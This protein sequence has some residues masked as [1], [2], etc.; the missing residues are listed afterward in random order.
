MPTSDEELSAKRQQYIFWL[1]YFGF[2]V[3]GIIAIGVIGSVIYLSIFGDYDPENKRVIPEILQNWGG[4]IVGF[5]FGTFA[6]LIK[7]F[8]KSG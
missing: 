8:I 5:F 1:V 4:I 2:A 6:G 7:D 3:G